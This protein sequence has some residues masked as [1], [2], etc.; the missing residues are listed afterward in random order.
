MTHEKYTAM[1]YDYAIME[2]LYLTSRESYITE[3]VAINKYALHVYEINNNWTGTNNGGKKSVSYAHVVHIYSN[4][5]R[6][7][8]VNS[9]IHMT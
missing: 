6:F 1:Q 9:N 5:L 7:V 8:Y 3:Y 2:E 4:L